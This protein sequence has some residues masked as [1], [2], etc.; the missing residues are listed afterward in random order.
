MQVKGLVFRQTMQEVERL[1][2]RGA[3]VLALSEMPAELR[4]SLR[5][6]GLLANGWYSVDWQRA[7]WSAIRAA[8]DAEPDMLKL[9]GHEA[10]LGAVSTVY[11]PF[12]RLLSPATM[13][14]IGAKLWRRVYDRG[15]Y[16]ITSS[17]RG[18]MVIRFEGCAGF[19][20]TMWTVTMGTV[21]AFAK[22]A[23]ARRV[24]VR[25]IAGGRDGD[26]WAEMVGR[27]E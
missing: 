6:D 14:S 15:G 18:R 8:T 1:F 5:A 26:D 23:G 13:A 20:R 16:V 4:D 3:A 24:S 11:R 7:M 27:W 22:L 25:L 21:E 10:V 9:I 12:L 2:G 19:D 17:E